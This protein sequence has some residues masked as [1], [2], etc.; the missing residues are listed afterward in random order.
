MG[1]LQGSMTDPKPPTS[2]AEDLAPV[3]VGR[4][5]TAIVGR[6]QGSAADPAPPNLGSG[7]YNSS[8]RRSPRWRLGAIAA[9]AGP[10]LM[11]IQ[12]LRREEPSDILLFS[13]SFQIFDFACGRH[14]YP[15]TKIGFSRA[16]ARPA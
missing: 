8:G 7:G 4:I 2:V 11:Q 14:N 10:S 9:V 1:R 5:Q 13:Y 16:G 3:I 15:H 6:L 12:G